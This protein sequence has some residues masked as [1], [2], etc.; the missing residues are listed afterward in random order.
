MAV[1]AIEELSIIIYRFAYG[2]D[3]HKVTVVLQLNHWHFHLKSLAM[4]LL[5][6]QKNWKRQRQYEQFSSIVFHLNPF[7]TR[8]Q[9]CSQL[10][11]LT[12]NSLN[13]YNKSKKSQSIIYSIRIWYKWYINY[14]FV[15][16]LLVRS[17][18]SWFNDPC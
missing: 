5:K 18:Q 6:L 17:D 7:S 16:K 4:H 10:K 9:H 15:K 1:T 11:L 13:I 2:I 12:K 3:F 8:A 14:A